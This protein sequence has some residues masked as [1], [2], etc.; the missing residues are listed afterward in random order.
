[1]KRLKEAIAYLW[2][3]YETESDIY[4]FP[5]IIEELDEFLIV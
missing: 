4:S 3:A 2:E 1:M 5:I